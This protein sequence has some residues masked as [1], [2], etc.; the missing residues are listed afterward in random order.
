MDSRR[1]LSAKAFRTS[2]EERL[3]TH[4]RKEGMDLQR[5]RR[6]VAFDRLL[7][8]LFFD[9]EGPWVLKGGY[10]MELEFASARSTVDIDLTVR[11]S[12]RTGGTVLRMLRAAVELSLHDF[13]E[14]RVGQPTMNL[15]TPPYGG[16]RYPVDAQMDGR[17]FVK[18]H[19][20]VSVGD[21][22]VDPLQKVRCADW[23]AFANVAPPLVTVTSREQQFAEKLHAYTLP[24]ST[25][26]SRVRDLVDLVLLV[27]SNLDRGLLGNAITATFEQRG[28]HPFPGELASPDASWTVPFSAHAR[29]CNLGVELQGAFTL[30][31]QV[32]AQIEKGR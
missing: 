20:D 22:L 13:F 15:A 21:V 16:S 19:V 2:L 3:K 29:Q 14:F 24:R 23:L 5:L 9:P 25:P 6:Q 28:T 17:S 7:A 8:R 11:R 10:A 18:F 1:F 31:A 27:K 12:E 26:N 4:A 30:V 32:F